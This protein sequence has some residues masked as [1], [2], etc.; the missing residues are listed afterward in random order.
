[1]IALLLAG[2]STILHA[3]SFE[4]R[5]L[6]EV[7]AI[8]DEGGRFLFNRIAGV[9]NSADG[10]IY[11]FDSGD[12]DVKIF[13]AAGK[14]M[15]RFG[16]R[17]QGPGEL[18]CPGTSLSMRDTLIVTTSMQSTRVSTFRLDGTLVD[19]KQPL[20][21]SRDA[22]NERSTPLRYGFRVTVP[23]S[24]VF[25]QPGHEFMT[26]TIKRTGRAR[27]DT[28][29]R[30]R[31]GEAVLRGK[32]AVVSGAVPSGFG[33]GGA[34]AISGDSVVAVVD[35]YDGSVTWYA[36]RDTGVAVI[37][38]ASLGEKAHPVTARDLAE[39]EA[40]YRN[41]SKTGFAGIRFADA[42]TQ[43]SVSEQAFFDPGG[44]LW[45][46]GRYGT[47]KPQTWRVFPRAGSPFQVDV[48]ADFWLMSARNDLMYG[49]SFNEDRTQVV[50]VYQARPVR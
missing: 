10:R 22:P 31:R 28:I 48:P 35:G 11:V 13:D 32:G 47:G 14:F 12:C 26:V 37:R 5:E 30:I 41:E 7:V 33:Q 34:Y 23:S 6:R 9:L 38:K 46:G 43:W 50:R 4:R 24:V 19:T 45:V 15:K 1:M 40:R 27:I 25:S 3:Q 2:W 44:A 21:A 42:P 17:G 29:A 16:Q 18:T 39:M 49:Y 8:D 20:P 36:I